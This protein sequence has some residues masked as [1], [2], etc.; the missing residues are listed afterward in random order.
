MNEIN[1]FIESLS[2]QLR[3]GLVI[4]VWF[5]PGLCFL[6]ALSYGFLFK[7]FSLIILLVLLSLALFVHGSAMDRGRTKD[8]TVLVSK[9]MF[10]ASILMLFLLFIVAIFI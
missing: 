10:A 6:L 9:I 4:F 7:P 3:L 5:V 8:K 1:D 2:P